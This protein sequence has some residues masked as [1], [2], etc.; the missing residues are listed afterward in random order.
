MNTRRKLIFSLA[1]GA[2]GP[3][4]VVEPLVLRQLE[5]GEPFLDNA[6]GHR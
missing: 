2:L 5:F 1:A 6:D 3:E 4:L